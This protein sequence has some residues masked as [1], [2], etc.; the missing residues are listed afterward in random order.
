MELETTIY[1]FEGFVIMI[2][3]ITCHHK[4][5]F[6]RIITNIMPM[7]ENVDN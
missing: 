7:P 1:I 6:T 3:T 2:I 4:I 5:S